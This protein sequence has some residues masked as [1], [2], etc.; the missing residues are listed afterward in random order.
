MASSNRKEQAKRE[1][2]SGAPPA[3]PGK[4]RCMSLQAAIDLP[5]CGLLLAGLSLLAQYLQPALPI[6]TLYTGLVGGGLCIL[7][8][9]LGRRVPQCRWGAMTVLMLMA[10][11]LMHQAVKLWLVAITG[12]S[13]SR[14]VA[15]V[16][17]IMLTFCV[18]M[19]A[20][21]LQAQNDLPS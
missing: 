20:N 2:N 19:W 12:E 16:I 8:G 18:G 21:L 3:E 9:L 1:I 17:T 11:I 5:L 14:I 15:V 4:R 10:C 13:K 7:S 6:L